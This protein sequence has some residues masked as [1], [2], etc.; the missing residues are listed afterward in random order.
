M[1]G[2][3]AGK[4]R[5]SGRRP[6]G[7]DRSAKRHKSYSIKQFL[8]PAPRPGEVGA[9]SGAAAAAPRQA[10]CRQARSQTALTK[11]SPEFF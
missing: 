8:Q 2:K 6:Q 4:S 1:A 7:D 11:L 10:S 9:G 5:P 3:S